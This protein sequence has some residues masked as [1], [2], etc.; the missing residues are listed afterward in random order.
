MTDTPDAAVVSDA[1]VAAFY[2]R[3]IAL[4]RPIGSE[5]IRSALTAALAHQPPSAGLEEAQA[6]A[7]KMF[8]AALDAFD[9]RDAALAQIAALEASNKAMRDDAERFQWLLHRWFHAYDTHDKVAL[10]VNSKEVPTGGIPALI[11]ASRAASSQPR[12]EGE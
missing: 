3:A 6:Q 2:A 4:G 9:Q 8:N 10:R 5:L 12:T 11:D 1:M 7:D